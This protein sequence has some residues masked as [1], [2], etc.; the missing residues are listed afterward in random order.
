[1]EL[2]KIE[3]LLE[4]YFEG[5]TTLSE[6]Q[7]LQDYFKGAQVASHLE[8][9]REL[10]GFFDKAKAETLSETINIK[11]LKAK[12]RSMWY[13][14]AALLV[15]A[16]GVT[17]YFS[18]QANKFTAEEQE[19]LVAFEQTKK[20]LNLLSSS[21]NQGASKMKY[22]NEFSLATNKLLNQ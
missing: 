4:A 10:F 14:V 17:F 1:M 3:K 11:P 19:A 13:P 18:L 21:F 20:A 15:V 6:E 22:L 12:Q 5:Q 8:V 7:L 9:Y 2:I 16:L